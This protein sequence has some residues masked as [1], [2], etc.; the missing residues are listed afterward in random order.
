MSAALGLDFGISCFSHLTCAAKS[1]GYGLIMKA[2]KKPNDL[3]MP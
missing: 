3:F 1:V 2:D